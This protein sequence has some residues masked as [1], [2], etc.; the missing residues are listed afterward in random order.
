MIARVL[1]ARYAMESCTEVQVKGCDT[2]GQLSSLPNEQAL[3]P[4]Y[5]VVPSNKGE[6]G[7]SHP[8]NAY[9]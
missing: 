7:Q 5:Y 2:K 8:G 6:K 1:N 3:R 4:E 9:L